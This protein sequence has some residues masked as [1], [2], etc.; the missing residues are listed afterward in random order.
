MNI[1]AIKYGRIKRQAKDKIIVTPQEITNVLMSL[2]KKDLPEIEQ[3]P[4]ALDMATKI[5]N[6]RHK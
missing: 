5:W 4:T 2:A 3:Q 1:N 6:T